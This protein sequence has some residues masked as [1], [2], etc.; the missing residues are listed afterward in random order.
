[1][2]R[3]VMFLGTLLIGALV[4]G[5][6]PK[7]VE[8][9][10]EPTAPEAHVKSIE[11]KEGWA[12]EWDNML[13]MARK[14]GSLHVYSSS[15]GERLR[16][17][18]S[19]FKSKYGVE[20]KLTIARSEALRS[21]IIQERRAGLFIADLLLEGPSSSIKSKSDGWLTPMKPWLVLPE[22][23]DQKLWY[24]GKMEWADVDEKYIPLYTNYPSH[25]IFINNKLVKPEGIRSY[26]DLLEPKWK[27]KIIMDDPTTD[28]SAQTAFQTLI[29]NKSAN[30]DF[31]RQ[32]V[33]QEPMIT[34]DKR[35][36]MD[37]LAK[38]KYFIAW[39]GSTSRLAEFMLAGAP[40][41]ALENMKEGNQAGSGG[42]AMGIMDKGPNPGAAR[43]FVNWF[44]SREGQELA[45]RDSLKQT[46]RVDISTEGIPS[47]LLRKPGVKYFPKPN[48]YEEWVSKYEDEY[49]D[50]ARQVFAP[51]LKP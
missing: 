46:A 37:W 4:L 24:G 41:M 25:P 49:N 10:A 11:A 26:Y 21:K 28:G 3:I 29:Y 42:S 33:A 7:P 18:T 50:L 19:L 30:L 48:E 13:S 12:V 5:C 6:A 31:F 15:A 27:G 23:T 36:L 14:E 9:K 39:G 45:Q 16:E 2:K 20:L 34:R 38:G 8:P 51:L 47:F 44:L 17:Q 1:M 32:L 40:V 43:V 22:V 35:L